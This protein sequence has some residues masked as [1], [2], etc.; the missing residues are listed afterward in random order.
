M[1]EFSLA[2]A[3]KE[4]ILS[5][6]CNRIIVYIGQ[7]QQIDIDLFKNAL[8]SELNG[9]DVN[10]SFQEVKAKFKCNVCANEFYYDEIDLSEEEK[11]DI[12]FLPESIHIFVKCPKCF[13]ND[14]KIV[15]GRGVFI[16]KCETK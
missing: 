13:S 12:H 9:M 2:R 10:V 15:E 8:L 6:N 16:E 1:H 14:F 11:E 3:A 7:I 4:T 5:L